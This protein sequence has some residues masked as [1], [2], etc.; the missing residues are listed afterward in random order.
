MIYETNRELIDSMK[1]SGVLH[2]AEIAKA[3]EE[4][5]RKYFIPD[6]YSEH[7][8]L[9]RPLPIGGGQTISQPSTVAFMLELLEVKKGDRVLDIGSGSGWTTGL[10]GSLVGESGR[11]EGIERVDRLV[12]IGKNNIAKLNM[13]NIGIEKA[14]DKLGKPGF[15]FD[16]ILVSAAAEE[17][18]KELFDQLNM[19][20]NLV[21]PIRSSIFKFKKTEQG[22][23]S[24]EYAGF[25]FVPLIY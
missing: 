17:L 2:S 15:T 5:D 10:L 7:I 12:E 16:A 8:Y 20:A 25:A 1:K 14:A 21:I 11:V 4:I 13:P 18:P 24:K 22:I 23:E 3:F 19:G 6:E 9:D